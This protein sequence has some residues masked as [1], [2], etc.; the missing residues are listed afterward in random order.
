MLAD[1]TRTIRAEGEGTGEHRRPR[2][3]L[4]VLFS[5]SELSL[6]RHAFSGAA[7]TT[8]GR[9]PENHIPLNDAGMSRH[10]AMVTFGGGGSVKVGDQGSHNGTFLNG[11]KV[12]SS[13][14]PAR[15]GDVV[16]CGTTLLLVVPDVKVYALWPDAATASPL[17]GG[18]D[19]DAVRQRIKAVAEQEM[20]VLIYGE[21]GTG[22]DITA[23]MLHE[24]SERKNGAFVPLNC[25]AVPESLFE[26]ELFGARKGAFT[27]AVTDRPGILLGAHNGTLFLDEVGEMPLSVQPRLLRAVEQGEFRPLGGNK[28]LRVNLRIVA[29]THRDLAREVEHGTFREDLYYRLCNTVITLP[30]LRQRRDDVVLLA[31]QHIACVA[32]RV[33]MSARLVEKLLLHSWPGN[34]RD[35]YRVLNSALVEARVGGDS[36]LTSAHLPGELSRPAPAG[37]L[38]TSVK[39][40]LTRNKGNVAHTAQDLGVQ[41]KAVYT[42]LKEHGLA[43]KDFRQP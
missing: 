23:S 18:P 31:Q 36:Q 35:L 16:R 33:T 2:P 15:Y 28:A 14:V 9:H 10:H 27:G 3:G 37:D 43:A 20:H 29:A 11:Q 12:T 26:A 17:M 24:Q 41:R 1:K 34:V 8:I 21:T 19:M 38:L 5:E 22:K 25:S 32:Q 30:P 42:V 40:A 39:E 7:E 4:L 13:G 6:S